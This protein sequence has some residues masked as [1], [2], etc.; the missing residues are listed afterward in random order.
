MPTAY[1]VAESAKGSEAISALTEVANYSFMI[2]DF[3]AAQLRADS[4]RK[5]TLK[6]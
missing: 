4:F 3:A 6:K 5:K 1:W 2:H